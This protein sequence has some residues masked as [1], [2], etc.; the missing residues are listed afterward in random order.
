MCT[1][2][3]LIKSESNTDK[4]RQ[5]RQLRQPDIKIVSETDLDLATTKSLE[6]SLCDTEP[7]NA[8]LEDDEGT[9]KE[10]ECEVAADDNEV[11][12][13]GPNQELATHVA[14]L[15]KQQNTQTEENGS[16]D[17]TATVERYSQENRDKIKD[18]EGSLDR[19]RDKSIEEIEQMVKEIEQQGEPEVTSVEFEPDIPEEPEAETKEGRK[20]MPLVFVASKLNNCSEDIERNADEQDLRQY[21]S[22]TP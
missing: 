20:K 9:T 17:E 15:F 7:A 21:I 12:N 5:S 3:N 6:F 2:V 18:A 11:D 13:E 10:S 16:R 1:D 22:T 8:F 19:S 14:R 4:Y